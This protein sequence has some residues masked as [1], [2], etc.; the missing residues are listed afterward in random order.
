M[1]HLWLGGQFRS[2]TDEWHWIDNDEI[3]PKKKDKLNFPPW[4]RIDNGLDQDPGSSS[5]LNLDRSDHVKPH[6]YG[7]DCASK[8]PFVCKISKSLQ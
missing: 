6:F 2:K 1:R 7:L 8:Q 5:C 4:A 3:I